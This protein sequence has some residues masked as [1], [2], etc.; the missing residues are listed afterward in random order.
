MT[1]HSTL[2]TPQT[3]TLLS[4]KLNA[5]LSKRPSRVTST[6]KDG[7]DYKC[8]SR[9]LQSLG[10]YAT[11]GCGSLGYSRFITVFYSIKSNN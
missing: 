8:G 9:S 2:V 10:S 7:G 1:E 6:G 11:F 4:F 5:C 3:Y